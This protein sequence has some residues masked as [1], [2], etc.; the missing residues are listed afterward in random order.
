MG[1]LGL[2]S[3]A[4]YENTIQTRAS[5][6]GGV[7]CTVTQGPV[8]RRAPCLV[9]H[10]AIATLKFLI[11]FGISHCYFGL[12]LVNHVLILILTYISV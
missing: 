9:E 3:L 11:L 1:A 10:S 7:T 8:F 2:L 5:L 4:L 12:S 6:M